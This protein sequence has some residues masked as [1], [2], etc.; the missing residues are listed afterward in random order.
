MTPMFD[1][2]TAPIP[3]LEEQAMAMVPVG[4]LERPEEARFV[5]ILTAIP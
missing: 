2:I 5:L 4:R 3:E 1:R